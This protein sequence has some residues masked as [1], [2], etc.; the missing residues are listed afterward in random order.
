MSSRVWSRDDLRNILLAIYAAKFPQVAEAKQ[1]EAGG[2]P[3]VLSYRWG[4]R[5]AIQSL[6]LA[7]GLPLQLLDHAVHHPGPI[8]QESSASTQHWWIGDL[9]NVIAAVYR[10]AIAAPARDPDLP[11]I[12]RYRQ[13]FGEVIGA[14]LQ[15]IGSHETPERWLADVRADRYWIITAEQSLLEGTARPRIIGS[16]A[17]EGETLP[18]TDEE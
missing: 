6:M 16:P 14:V 13:G 10:S 8:P 15:A 3:E 11:D 17:E 1:S 18:P 4:Y 7:C 2:S 12:E 9:E 5:V